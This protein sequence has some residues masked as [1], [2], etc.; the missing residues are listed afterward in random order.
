MKKRQTNIVVV[1]VAVF[2]ATFMTA[3]EGTIVTTAMPTIVGSLKGIS[4]M[5]WVFSIY[6][7]TQAMM[8]PIYGKLTDTIGRKP[9]FIA[10]I[11]IFI[12]GSALSGMSHNMLTLIIARAVQGIGA[13]S[14]MPV[15]LTLLADMYDMKKRAKMLGYNS[16]AWG[17]ASIFGPLVGGIIVEKW[18][19]HW[20][21]FINLPIGLVLILLISTFLVEEKKVYQKKP[22]DLLGSGTLMMLLLSVLLAVQFFGTELFSLRVIGL[23]IAAILFIALFIFAEKRAVDPVMPLHLFRNR[24]FVLVNLVAFLLSGVLI[25]I[26]VYI[27]M[28]LQGV[29][30]KSAMIGGVAL[31][32]MSIFWMEGAFLTSKLLPK[33]GDKKVLLIGTSILAVA[34]AWLLFLPLQTSFW[35]FVAISVVWGI[36]FGLA[37]T[38]FTVSVQSG[39]PAG[40][41][42]VATSF[43]T[44]VRTLGQTILVSVFGVV[45]NS[46]VAKNMLSGAPKGI[47]NQLINP[48][49]VTSIPAK[50]IEP[51]RSVLFSGIR[52]VFGLSF[53]LIILTLLI[54]IGYKEARRN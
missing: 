10:G 42:G 21:F 19:W 45:L 31:A 52:G 41:L 44:L 27:P 22:M 7:L 35:W 15:S 8:T 38:T 25:G 53:G 14:I 29:L 37:F 3:V 24:A 48:H 50:M 6:L 54:L 51:L 43:N 17:I 16:A 2:V 20:I 46:L 12:V 36:G 47:M 34:G 39:V 9:V 33:Y 23:I 1:T 5:N 13:G 18:S 32:P 4:I 49:T 30:G 28:W 40:E 11:F 26:D